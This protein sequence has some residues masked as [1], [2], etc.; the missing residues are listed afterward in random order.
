LHCELPRIWI[1]VQPLND[2]WQA[3]I[4]CAS[5]IF[6]YRPPR[7]IHEGS[8]SIDVQH[9]VIVIGHHCIGTDVDRKD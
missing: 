6:P 4:D 3:A 5:L 7:A 2:R 8:V 9:E 1:D